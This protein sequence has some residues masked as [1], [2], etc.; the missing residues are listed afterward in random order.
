M[1]GKAEFAGRIVG[2]HGAVR[3]R[4]VADREVEDVRQTRLGEILVPDA[5]VRIEELCDPGG[6]SVHLDAGQRELARQALPARGRRRGPFR[7][8]ARARARRRSPSC[9][10]ARQMARIM[11]SGVKCAYCVARLRFARS[12]RETSSSSSRPRSSHAG[13]KPSPAR[14]K[15]LSARSVA[16][17]AVNFARLLLLVRSGVTAFGLDRRHEPDRGEIVSSARLPAL[18]ETAIAGEAVIVGGD[19]RL[20]GVGRVDDFGLFRLEGHLRKGRGL[21]VGAG[22]PP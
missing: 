1:Q 7:N 19:D 3:E 4:R 5:G 18:G 12:S 14:R 17:K 16:P 9:C 11:N 15:S 6:H 20:R 13:A 10:S 21:A 22:N 2:A 8:R